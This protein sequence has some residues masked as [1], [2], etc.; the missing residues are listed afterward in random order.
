[1]TR[2]LRLLPI[3]AVV[4]FG[5]EAIADSWSVRKLSREAAGAE[6][7]VETRKAAPV[8]QGLPDG[9][10]ATYSGHG[11]V[12]AAWYGTPTRRYGHGVIGD[13]I[14]AGALHVRT[15]DQTVKTFV[16]PKN[17]VFEDRY[18]R[19]ADLDGDG[20]VEIVTIRSSLA[21][22]AGVTV[23]GLVDGTVRQRAA[24]PFIG[25]ANR[26]LNIAGI[27]DFRGTGDR[28]IAYVKTPHI[29]GTLL[30]YALR[31][32]ELEQVGQL[33][34]FSNHAI[35]SRELRLSAVVDLNQDGR[36]DLAL[37]SAN[38][39][40]LR[41]AGFDKGTLR[42]LGAVQLPGRVNGAIN[43]SGA[44]PGTSFVVGLEGGTIVAVT[45]R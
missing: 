25:R 30:I 36:M 31:G 16:L 41:F 42:A 2:S 5:S 13:A 27:A 6:I 34:G 43:V 24:T 7:A 10:I 32:N 20:R 35:G 26:W 23:Y 4:I 11:D 9:L 12:T 40:Q 14:E 3:I 29:G 39:R 8:D 33:D 22:G 17:E 21:A 19:M 15:S 1:M 38:R 28:Q 44:G 18:P 37:P 45:R